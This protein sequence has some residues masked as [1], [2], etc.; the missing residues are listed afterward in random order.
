MHRRARRPIMSPPSVAPP[1]K[2]ATNAE[3][4][5]ARISSGVPNCTTAP[6]SITATRSA[7]RKASSTSCVTSTTVLRRRVFKA[8]NSSCRRRAGDRIERAERLVHQHD[9]RIGGERAGEADALALAAAELRGIAAGDCGEVEPEQREQLARAGDAPLGRP[10]EQARHDLDVGERGQV[11]EQAGVLHD[12]AHAAAQRRSGRRR[13]CRGR[14]CARAPRRLEQPVDELQRR[15]LAA[16][17]RAEQRQRRAALDC[18]RHLAQRHVPVGVDLADGF[19]LDHADPARRLTP[20]DSGCA[21]ALQ[22]AEVP[23]ACA[24]SIASDQPPCTGY[25]PHATMPRYA[26]LTSTPACV[27]RPGLAG[28]M[29]RSAA[30]ALLT[31]RQHQPRGHGR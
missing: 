26:A 28:R 11:R 3:A 2:S 27:A 23:P 5:A 18:E 15:R 7:R 20:P 4:G 1:T 12:V 13:R 29:T 10:A 31:G 14:R 6:S 16:P 24:P 30:A 25:V 8:R 17:G 22:P 21:P 9:R 19:E